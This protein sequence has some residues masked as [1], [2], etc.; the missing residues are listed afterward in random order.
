MQG[1][2][3]TPASLGGILA[4]ARSP[5]GGLAERA[6]QLGWAESDITVVDTDLGVSG[7]FS[8]LRAG[9]QHLV[10]RVCLGKIGA[11]FGLEVSRLARSSAELGRLLWR[12]RAELDLLLWGA[13]DSQLLH[14]TRLSGSRAVAY[15]AHQ[16]AMACLGANLR[17]ESLPEAAE[18][19]TSADGQMRCQF[20]Q[21]RRAEE[22]A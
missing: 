20:E 15:A 5:T 16:D 10:A 9:F 7:R 21:V 6:R 2:A 1:C 22:G 4:R 11:V 12:V 3:L 19:W 14:E 8:G 18:T 17:N 13:H